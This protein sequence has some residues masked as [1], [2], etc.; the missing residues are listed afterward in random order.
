M[1]LDQLGNYRKI[2]QRQETWRRMRQH[3]TERAMTLRTMRRLN[4]EFEQLFPAAEQSRDDDTPLPRVREL[5]R[6]SAAARRRVEKQNARI[7]AATKSA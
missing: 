3:G 2:W 7:E 5:R 6:K 1:S 4:E